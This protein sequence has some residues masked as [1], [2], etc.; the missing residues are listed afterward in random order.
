MLAKIPAGMQAELRDGY[1]AVFDTEDLKTEP[2]P[3]LVE[4]VKTR[5]SAFAT[6]T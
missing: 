4:L 3:R 6:A 1:W 5:L 2:G